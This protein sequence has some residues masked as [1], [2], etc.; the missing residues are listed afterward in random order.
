MNVL[1]IGGANSLMNQLIRKV[2]KEGHRVY[3]LTGSRY[4]AGAYEKVFERYDLSYDSEQLSD[5]FQSVSPDV[6]VFTGA[7]DSNFRW[8]NE[9]RELVRLTSSLTS[10]LTAHTMSGKGRFIFLS[11]EE[12]YS[13]S[14]DASIGEETPRSPSQ[15][16][17]MALAQC[18]DICASFRK[19]L[20][21]NVIV[22][23]VDHY[24][25]IPK[26]PED[27]NDLCSRMCLE[28]MQTGTISADRNR[29]F[30]L[31]YESDAVEFIY[32]LIR[33]ATSEYQVYNLSSSKELTE[34]DVAHYI[35]AAM[36]EDAH[37]TIEEKDTGGNRC[38]LSNAR[39]DK[40]FGARIFADAQST[41]E[42]LVEYMLAH[43]Y[44]FL[45]GEQEGKPFF[46]RVVDKLKSFG[47]AVFPYIENL[48][49]YLIILFVGKSAVG[50]EYLQELDLFLLY[51]LLF[52]AVYGQH[53]AT[54]SAILAVIGSF[55]TKLQDRSLLSIAMDYNT[56]IWIAQL[57]IVG[58][59]VGYLKDQINKLNL[60]SE[61][62]QKFLSRQ[63]SDIKDIN[64]SN[65]RVKDALETEIINQTDSVGKVYQI[66]SRLEQYMPEEVLFYAAEIMRDILG[67]NDI[68]IYTVSNQS[69]A[70]L[71][72][73]TSEQ[74]KALGKSIR[75]R[76]LEDVYA[77]M[78][79]HK[80]FINRD[81]NNNY[82]MMANAVFDGDDMQTM[83]MVWGL[84]WERMTLGQ[85]DMLTIVSHLIQDAILRASR[86][87]AMLENRRYQEGSHVMEVEAFTSLLRAF[88][89]A[90]N[91]NLTECA[92]LRVEIPETIPEAPVKPAKIVRPAAPVKP[93]SP[94]AP[95][96]RAGPEKKEA[97]SISG[98]V[99]KYFS[100]VF[101]NRNKEENSSREVIPVVEAEPVVKAEAEAVTVTETKELTVFEK[102]GKALSSLVRQDDYIGTLDDGYLY[103]LLS[104]SN[105]ADADFVV[106]RIQKE[107]YACVLLEDFGL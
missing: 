64:S 36:G 38:I 34:L 62:E 71:F 92:V 88:L 8:T 1:M 9:E 49:F 50:V 93:A 104:N 102:T 12:I 61:E 44:L 18:E 66:T 21:A 57:F 40:E 23:R 41:V 79:A 48:V 72:A 33:C 47:G 75:Y 69:Y 35:Q 96:K 68:A 19:N 73:F 28:A 51:V 26:Q 84:P 86:Y 3:L 58:L 25:M 29:V 98:R 7:F 107:G 99:V 56:Y 11:S 89:N 80:V 95:V 10:L 43:K 42:K 85:A 45:T 77:A 6:T 101:S 16:K 70:R 37:I 97:T 60:E 24:Y 22:L 67:S 4:S 13:E 82:P 30:S 74:A 78:S 59:V 31:L 5:V 76:E 53:Q 54:F 63:L 91:N 106:G 2:K 94:A 55:I 39:F 52:A 14:F 105:N 103:I 100:R 90:R 32:K 87:I 27:V 65:I 81:L 83:I 15:L 20:E 46:R 17:G